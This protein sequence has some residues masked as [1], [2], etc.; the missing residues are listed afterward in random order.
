MK[1]GGALGADITR[2]AYVRGSQLPTDLAA[3]LK[4]LPTGQPTPLFRGKDGQLRVMV[5]CG[6]A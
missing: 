1:V 4:K 2:N 6:R 5:I 3:I